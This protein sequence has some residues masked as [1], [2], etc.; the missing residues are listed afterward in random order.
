ML[1]HVGKFQYEFFFFEVS[2]LLKETGTAVIHTIVRPDTGI[3]NDW[4]DEYIFPVGYIPRCSE[5][6][7][8]IE[9]NGMKLQGCFIHNGENYKRTLEEWLKNLEIENDFFIQ[10]TKKNIKSIN[11][12]I[13]SKELDYQC[14]RAYRMWYFYL[15]S[16]RTIFDR[17]GGGV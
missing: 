1:E 6:I 13:A 16:I 14:R 11:P 17:S 3:T 4:I 5:V 10:S 7:K 12:E 2:S 8:G 15:S 9:D